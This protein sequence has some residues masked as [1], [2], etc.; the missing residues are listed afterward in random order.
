VAGVVALVVVVVVV[1][2]VEDTV[3]FYDYGQLDHILNM[4]PFFGGK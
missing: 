1:V 3:H 4:L 2:V